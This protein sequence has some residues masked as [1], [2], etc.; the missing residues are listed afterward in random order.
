LSIKSFKQQQNKEVHFIKPVW[1]WID[2]ATTWQNLVSEECS[3]KLQPCTIQRS[4]FSIQQ[5]FSKKQKQYAWSDI[6]FSIEWRTISEPTLPR[7][8]LLL[9]SLV[10]LWRAANNC[11]L[12]SLCLH[13]SDRQ[14]T[15]TRRFHRFHSNWTS[16]LPAPPFLTSLFRTSIVLVASVHFSKNHNLNVTICLLLVVK[17]ILF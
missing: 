16:Y 2:C 4:T 9:R 15:V 17:L 14:S 8:I 12:C 13:M 10:C 1:I 11:W 7:R 6:Q 5:Q 3:M